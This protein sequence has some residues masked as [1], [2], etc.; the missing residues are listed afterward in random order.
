MLSYS[1]ESR[2]VYGERWGDS[3]P[4]PIFSATLK[5]CIENGKDFTKGGAKYNVA[6][7][8]GIGFATLADY[9]YAIKKAVF[10][11][12]IISLSE[13]CNVLSS[14]FCGADDVRMKLI[15]YPKF[16]HGDTDADEFSGRVFSDI[17]DYVE[18]LDNERGG[19]Y[20][21]STFTY[22]NHLWAA[23]Y[24]RATADG[25]RG[26]EVLSQSTGPSRIRGVG[27]L[28]DA[29]RAQGALPLKESGGISVLDVMLPTGT[30]LN[31]KTLS[32]T[33]R[34]F[35]LSGGQALQPNRVTVERMIEAKKEPD[36]HRD[37]I[38][39]VCGLSVYFVNLSENFQ[40]DMIARNQYI[41]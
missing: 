33:V 41:S 23:P 20:V 12:K 25:R 30:G 7:A 5:G 10:E 24:L 18:T 11:D 26:G 1:T 27:S 9:L 4:S 38:V 14:D 36:K 19:K 34:A 17:N 16:G 29:I 22:G 15:S 2:R 21:F 32:A 39:R 3:H 6:T 37:L 31:E 28:T 35:C 13:L 8:S 40:D